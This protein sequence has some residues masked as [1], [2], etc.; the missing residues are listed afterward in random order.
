MGAA[1]PA[2]D[3]QPGAVARDSVTRGIEHDPD[4][5]GRVSAKWA[6]VFPRDKRGTRLRGDHAQI[7]EMERDDYS[8]KSHHAPARARRAACSLA[9]SSP[10]WCDDRVSGLADTIRKPLV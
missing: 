8:K 3:R 7:K 6:P 1:Q 2:P 5:E 9:K 4:P 10:A